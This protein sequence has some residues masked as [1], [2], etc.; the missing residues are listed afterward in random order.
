MWPFIGKNKA[1]S[2]AGFVGKGNSLFGG[3]ISRNES[4]SKGSDRCSD[5]DNAQGFK[6]LQTCIYGAAYAK[7]C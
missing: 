3:E 4:N 1:R 5:D 7:N 2:G 6:A